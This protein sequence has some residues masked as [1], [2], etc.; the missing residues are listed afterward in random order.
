MIFGAR[1][2]D[3]FNFY[4]GETKLEIVK[5]YKYL[6][7]YFSPSGSFLTARKH[8]ASQAYK[9]M[10][11]LNLRIHNLDLPID[12]L[13]KL[14]DQTVLP[15]MTYGCG[16]WGFESCKILE[17]LTSSYVPSSEHVRVPQST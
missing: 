6:G 16:V 13:L 10:H 9:A 15:I 8:I 5:A 14:F 1:K 7:T 11:L 12:L 4:I 17:S 2:T 3:G